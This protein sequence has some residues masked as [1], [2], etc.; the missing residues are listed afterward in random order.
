MINNIFS[1]DL[2]L[3]AG[4]YEGM[5][6]SEADNFPMTV[7]TLLLMAKPPVQSLPSKEQLDRLDNI[8]QCGLG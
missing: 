8:V 6:S 1:F 2:P 7:Q 3:F 4:F 5:M